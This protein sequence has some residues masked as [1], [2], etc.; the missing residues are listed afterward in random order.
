L[1]PRIPAEVE[2]PA[3]CCFEPVADSCESLVSDPSNAAQGDQAKRAVD[4]VGGHLSG[5]VLPVAAP[6]APRADRSLHSAMRQELFDTARKLPPRAPT[7]RLIVV[8]D[9]HFY[10]G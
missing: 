7:T 4:E 9:F 8:F 3:A 6:E 5:L 2:W 10:G 1:P